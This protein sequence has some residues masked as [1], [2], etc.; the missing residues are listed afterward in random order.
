M[1]STTILAAEAKHR[2]AKFDLQKK[3]LIFLGKKLVSHYGCMQ[4]HAINGAEAMSSPC[5]NLSD[6]GQKQVSKLDYGY[7]SEHA[8]SSLPPT[9][10]PPCA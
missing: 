6:W 8:E 4:C 9:S 7:L 10:R 5:A 1:T 3:Q 2:V